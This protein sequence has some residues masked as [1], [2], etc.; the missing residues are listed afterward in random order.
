MKKL[1]TFIA[2]ISLFG[3]LLG[4]DAIAQRGMQWRG[5]EGWGPGSGY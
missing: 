5:S 4:P 2:A 1:G 3:L